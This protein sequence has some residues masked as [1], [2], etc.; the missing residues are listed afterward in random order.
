MSSAVWIGIKPPIFQVMVPYIAEC[1]C[2]RL[3]QRSGDCG[4]VSCCT[5]STVAEC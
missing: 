5:L 3:L 4:M 1:V 2:V